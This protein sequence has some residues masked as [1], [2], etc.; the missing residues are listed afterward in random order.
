MAMME[1]VGIVLL[2]LGFILIGVEMVVPGF[3]APGIGGITCLILGVIIS[4]DSVEEGITITII[5]I[6]LLAVMLTIMLLVMRKIRHPLILEDSMK[7]E[8]GF[9]SGQDLEYLVGKAG[10][11]STDLR[12]SGKCSID[13][14]EFDVRTEGNYL[15]GG[16]K[17][18]IKKIHENTIIVQEI[19]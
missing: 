13:G 4:A 16:T 10:I 9:L 17:V 19:K 14:V 1:V 15:S 2:V 7:A 3:G 18:M 5:V 8:P 11:A 6:V 12:P